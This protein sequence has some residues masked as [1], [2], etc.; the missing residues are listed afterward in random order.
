MVGI[1]FSSKN[2]NNNNYKKYLEKLKIVVLLKMLYNLRFILPLNILLNVATL[3]SIFKAVKKY[4]AYFM[5]DSR[6]LKDQV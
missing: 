6:A 2:K 3:V 1:F 4:I 5:Q